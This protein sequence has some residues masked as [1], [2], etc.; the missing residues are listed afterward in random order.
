M[1]FK[2]AKFGTGMVLNIGLIF[3]TNACSQTNGGLPAFTQSTSSEE[4]RID[5]KQQVAEFM[6]RVKMAADADFIR[7][8][9]KFHE[10]TGVITQQSRLPDGTYRRFYEGT[11][12]TGL[13]VLNDMMK[14]P[15]FAPRRRSFAYGVKHREDFGDLNSYVFAFGIP[16][17]M[18][19][20]PEETKEIFG[21]FQLYV[22]DRRYEIASNME[23]VARTPGEA[24]DVMGVIDRT[25]NR[26][27]R[28]F[29]NFTYESLSSPKPRCL[30]KVA[31][32]A[33]NLSIK[34][35]FPRHK[36]VSSKRSEK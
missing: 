14:P 9:D 27:E 28:W 29:L 18:C 36:L 3:A 5:E 33:T 10:A 2:A 12:D 7:F 35:E 25:G 23:A 26:P 11:F 4:R 22:N 6:K 19:F 16:E 24:W 32:V 8:P 20:G 21:E 34:T 15:K 13:D 31:V 30:E 1:F 17:S